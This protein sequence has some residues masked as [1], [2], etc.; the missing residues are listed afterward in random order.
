M[1]ITCHNTLVYP[2]TQISCHPD[3]VPS[4]GSECPNR[5]LKDLITSLVTSS[6]YIVGVMGWLLSQET[7]P[8]MLNGQ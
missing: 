5:F 7:W 4:Q 8:V 1:S 2:R 3:T 6:V